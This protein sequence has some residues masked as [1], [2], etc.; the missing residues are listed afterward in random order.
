MC[1]S[2]SLK[3]VETL[4]D[5]D[6]LKS[7]GVYNYLTGKTD[8]NNPAD[9]I[10]F[11]WQL[12]CAMHL[13]SEYAADWQSLSSAEFRTVFNKCGRSLLDT[14]RY[15]NARCMYLAKGFD[16]YYAGKPGIPFGHN[17]IIDIAE[18]RDAIC[19]KDVEGYVNNAACGLDPMELR[20]AVFS[21]LLDNVRRSNKISYRRINP[22]SLSR[23]WVSASE[24]ADI[25]ANKF[26]NLSKHTRS[27]VNAWY[28]L[29]GYDMKVRCA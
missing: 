28:A 6:V 13:P 25:R 16:D 4:M 7:R 5:N 21:T 8:Y 19:L 22:E 17:D 9:V 27:I 26:D 29:S 18:I 23:Y 15:M 24:I 12:A 3:A 1:N 11:Y 2:Y 20:R 14:Y 10:E